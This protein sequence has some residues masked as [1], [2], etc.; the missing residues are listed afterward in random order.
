MQTF[1][2]IWNYQFSIGGSPITVG[3]IVIALFLVIIGYAVSRALSKGLSRALIRRFTIESGQA[4]ALETFSFY[5]FFVGVV[6]TALRLVEFPLTVFTIAGG[7][8]AIGV[9]FGSQELM[10][11]FISGLI[12]L[13]ERPVRVGDLVELGGTYG[14][15]EAI[16]ARHG[17]SLH[18]SSHLAC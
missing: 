16:G 8:L 4:A 5:L 13:M 2:N 11:N 10:N 1:A 15:I 7:A 14:H 6:V 18:E 12:M 17:I 3:T 9:G